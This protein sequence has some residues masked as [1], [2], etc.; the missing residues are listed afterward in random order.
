MN[1]STTS[2]VG[3]PQS[4]LRMKITLE[5]QLGLAALSWAGLVIFTMAVVTGVSFARDIVISGWDVATGI[6][7][8]YA[9]FIG[10]YVLH[11]VLPIHIAHGRTRRD[12][13]I[14]VLAFS[15]IFT[16]LLALLATAGFAIEQGLYALAGWSREA[17]DDHLFSSYTDYA[18]IFAEYWLMVLVWTAAGALIGAAIYR[19]PEGGWLAFIPALVL[20]GLAGLGTEPRLGPLAFIVDRLDIEADPSLPLAAAMS[21]ACYLAA[22]AMTWPIMRDMPLRNR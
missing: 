15:G 2:R 18:T 3:T 17:P 14:E 12:F 6:I 1:A 11:T 22:L 5:D 8:W 4:T 9:A 21:V 19:S 10:G 13:A 20:V 16:T 7:P